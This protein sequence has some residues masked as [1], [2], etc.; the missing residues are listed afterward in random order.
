MHSREPSIIPEL[1]TQLEACK[2]LPSPPGVAIQIVGL[3]NDPEAN[4]NKIAKVL[5]T[6]PAITAKILRI[7]NSPMYTQQRKT[8]NLRRAVVVLGLNATISLALSFSLLKSFRSEDEGDG[9]DYP[10]YWRRALLCATVSRSLAEVAGIADAEELFLSA[11]IQDIGMLALDQSVPGVYEH[12]EGQAHHA[13]IT[14]REIEK[15]GVDHAAVGGWLL[16]RWNFPDRIQQAVA[17]SHDPE[18]VPA[19]H[20]NGAFVRC[21]ALSGLVGEVFLD[22]SGEGRFQ[23]L[24][25]AA[26]GHFGIDNEKV[27]ELLEE[28]RTLIPEAERVFETQILVGGADDS[29]MDEARE[30]L[31]LRSLHALQT[32]DNLQDQAESIET[33]T[34]EL[35]ETNRRDALT[36]LFNRGHLDLH[37]EQA[38]QQASTDGQPLSIAFADLDRFKSIND[39]YGHQVGDQILKTAAKILKANVRGDDLV[40][41][42]GGEEFI[43][44]LLG[45]DCELAKI[46]SQRIVKSFEATRHNV[47]GTDELAVTIS[48]G[49]A[50]HNDGR[51]FDSVDEFVKAADKALYTAKLQGRNC[52]I[53]FDVIENLQVAQT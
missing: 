12:L 8:E 50:T 47:G 51:K 13:V 40:A 19:G 31:M 46:I 23:A 35:E 16:E 26:Q 38:L 52:S 10:L 9:L 39:T 15:L 28:V 6:D 43:I 14:A 30:A 11:L 2:T 27:G 7:A 32:V 18:I 44:V 4:M 17:A 22:Q 29:I 21:V 24:A 48:V 25:D 41:R 37:L 45:T 33:R 34:K 20:E 49:I 1:T 53:P 36:G 3:A 42:Y 5:A